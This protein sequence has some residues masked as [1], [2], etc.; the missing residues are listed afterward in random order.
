MAPVT[1]S[2]RSWSGRRRHRRGRAPACGPMLDEP[3]VV[4]DEH[5]VGPLGRGQA[6]GDGD[7][8][9]ARGELSTARAS[10][11]SVAGS[12]ADVASSR[13]RQLG[14]ATE[15]RANETSW[16]SPTES[17]SPR[18]P[19]RVASPLGR[20]ANHP[21]SPSSGE[22]R[23][24][25]VVGCPGLAEADVVADGRVEEEPLLGDHH[26]RSTQRAGLDLAQVDAGRPTPN[27][28][29]DRPAGPA[30][31]PAWSCPIPSPRPTPPSN[32]RRSRHR[33]RRARARRC[34]RSG[35]THAR[36]ATPAGRPG[37]ATPGTGSGRSTGVSSRSRIRRQPATAVWVWSTMSVNSATG[38]RNKLTRKMNATSSPRRQAAG[39]SESDAD[40]EH[41][42]D[43]DDREELARGEQG[44]RHDAG[45]HLG[46]ALGGRWRRA[47][48]GG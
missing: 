46:L 4:Q 14:S 26:Q 41:G 13:I 44:G 32:R 30:A 6:V 1:S 10:V 22:G 18:S 31:W 16:R 37:A 17:C 42:R 34:R 27:R 20:P 8:R 25:F 15:A 38:W 33:C 12:T 23:D 47:C 5:E 36:P 24:E 19:T 39:G 9:A 3:A 43:G 2:H 45:P 11:T 7:G 29:S 40:D 35:M 28:P 21:S 48:D